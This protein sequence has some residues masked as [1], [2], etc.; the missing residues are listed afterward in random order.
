MSREGSDGSVQTSLEQKVQDLSILSKIW[1]SSLKFCDFLL[2]C[3]F[4]ISFYLE[5]ERE[6]IYC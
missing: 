3:D 4:L 1:E 5:V 6:F 2:F